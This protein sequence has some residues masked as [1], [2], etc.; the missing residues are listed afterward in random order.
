MVIVHPLWPPSLNKDDALPCFRNTKSVPEYDAD[1]PEV[2]WLYPH[3]VM[4]DA[5]YID[6]SQVARV[7][8]LDVQ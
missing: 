2:K 1:V 7:V 3:E 5:Y 6:C 8:K 4:R